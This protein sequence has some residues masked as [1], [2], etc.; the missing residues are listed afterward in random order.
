MLCAVVCFLLAVKPHTYNYLRKTTYLKNPN[1]VLLR[2]HLIAPIMYPLNTYK[3]IS[4]QRHTTVQSTNKLNL[5]SIQK[6]IGASFFTALLYALNHGNI[7]L[8]LAMMLII[9]LALFYVE[10]TAEST[11]YQEA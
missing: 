2:I 6:S 9:S 7:T 5:Q 1:Y 3:I 10:F 4:H 11:I 8:G